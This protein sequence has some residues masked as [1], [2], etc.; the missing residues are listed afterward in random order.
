[1]A[2]LDRWYRMDRSINLYLRVVVRI[3]GIKV[4]MVN[5]VLDIIGHYCRFAAEEE[6]L[7]DCRKLGMIKIAASS[8][9]KR[10]RPIFQ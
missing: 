1:M 6:L 7:N 9:K 2:S 4:A 10:I 8:G 3:E 5:L